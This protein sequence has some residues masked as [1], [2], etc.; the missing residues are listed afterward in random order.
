MCIISETFLVILSCLE[1]RGFAGPPGASA[2]HMACV[3]CGAACAVCA[4]RELA[5]EVR[6]CLPRVFFA[7]ASASVG[8]SGRERLAD[9]AAL[10]LDQ[11]RP[12]SD[13]VAFDLGLF[14]LGQE[15][16][17]FRGTRLRQRT[18]A[19]ALVVRAWQMRGQ[20]AARPLDRWLSRRMRAWCRMA[21]RAGRQR[22]MMVRSAQ[23]LWGQEIESWRLWYA[24]RA[25][26]RL[27]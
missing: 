26:I 21:Q 17:R 20:A 16:L 9:F 24:L 10:V 19:L 5:A 4:R 22:R 8:L 11:R 1:R 27:C 3:A 18:R 13:V 6:R 2:H 12:V 25:W 15:R 14:W 7:W 23:R